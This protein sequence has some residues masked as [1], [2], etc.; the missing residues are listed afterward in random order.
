MVRRRRFEL[1]SVERRAWE[2]R[3]SGCTWR[4]IADEIGVSEAV[5]ER[6]VLEA[7]K[8][9]RGVKQ[10]MTIKTEML[11][12]DEERRLRALRERLQGKQY[13]EIARICG[14]ADAKAAKDAVMEAIR[15]APEPV[16]EEIRRI[17]IARLD[18]LYKVAYQKAVESGDPRAVNACLNI[19]ERRWKLYNIGVD[20]IRGASD[21]LRRR[22]ENLS[23][24]QLIEIVERGLEAVTNSRVSDEKSN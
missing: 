10:I 9:M 19:I 5:A 12:E 2:M 6:L 18:E 22:L 16:K 4:E 1:T 17:D 20:S 3:V 15:S 7:E 14:Y 24:E 13:E 21:D 23:D 11:I 8:K